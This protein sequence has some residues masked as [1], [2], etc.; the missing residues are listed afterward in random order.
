M[1]RRVLTIDEFDVEFDPQDSPSGSTIWERKE[2]L[3]ARAAGTITEEQIWVADDD[4]YARDVYCPGYTAMQG[5][6]YLVTAKSWPDT[7]IVALG[8]G[9]EV[10]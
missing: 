5:Y 7:D 2:V 4:E 1:T 3:A 9:E 10:V 8:S 6:G